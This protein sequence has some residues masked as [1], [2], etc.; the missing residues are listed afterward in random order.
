MMLAPALKLLH[1]SHQPGSLSSSYLTQRSGPNSGPAIDTLL[2]DP[3]NLGS[4]LEGP[5]FPEK[6]DEFQAHYTLLFSR[7][8]C[9]TEANGLRQPKRHYNPIHSK[10]DGSKNTAAISKLMLP[11]RT[12]GEIAI[13]PDTADLYI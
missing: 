11:V 8:F 7:L 1:V 2:Q 6:S 5:F 9:L 13:D 3:G 4:I 12:F 10:G